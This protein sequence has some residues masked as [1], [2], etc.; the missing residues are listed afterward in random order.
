MVYGAKSNPS[1]LSFTSSLNGGR[2]LFAAVLQLVPVYCRDPLPSIQY[3]VSTRGR[4]TRARRRHRFKCRLAG[5]KFTTIF[6][7]A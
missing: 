1:R 4:P 3:T 6:S 7:Y 5:G 2:V